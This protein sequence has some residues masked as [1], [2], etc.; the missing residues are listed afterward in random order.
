M[1]DGCSSRLTPKQRK[2]EK[3][4]VKV[5]IVG[6]DVDV[7][8]GQSCKLAPCFIFIYGLLSLAGFQHTKK[9]DKILTHSD[10]D[11]HVLAYTSYQGLSL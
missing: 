9:I 2:R 3:A 4:R 1:L 11:L 10:H 8:L 5:S 7:R 6:S